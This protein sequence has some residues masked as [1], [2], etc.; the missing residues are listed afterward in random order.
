MAI[1]F[2]EEFSKFVS[3]GDGSAIKDIYQILPSVSQDQ[4]QIINLLM[5]Y[6]E[7]YDLQD[8]KQYVV[9]FRYDMQ[10]NKNLGFLSSMN[11]K[12]LISA[13]TMERLVQG[14]KPT[15]SHQEEQ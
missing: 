4:M 8:L 6:I 5:F 3:S 9:N 13:Y 7:R 12:T 1:D 15:I 14:V 11:M 2:E 10:K